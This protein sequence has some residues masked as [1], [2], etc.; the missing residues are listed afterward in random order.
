MN[1]QK[2]CD[3]IALLDKAFPPSHSFVDGLLCNVLAREPGVRLLLLVSRGE[4]GRDNPR[5]YLHTLCWPR[6]FERRGIGRFLNVWSAYFAV[7]KLVR[8]ACGRRTVL[9]V[10]NDPSMLLA[11]ALQRRR[12]DRLVFQSSF[13]HEQGPSIKARVAR[14]MYRLASA[15]V[16]A[17]MGVSPD[18]LARLRTLFP[19]ARAADIVPLLA[20]LPDQTQLKEPAVPDKGGAVRFVYIGLHSAARKLEVVLE[21]I[22]R[23]VQAGANATFTFVGGSPTEHDVLR[24][25]EGVPGLLQRGCLRFVEKVP[26]AEITR[27]LQDADVGLSLIP[28]DPHFKEAS[29]TKVS[30]YMTAGL[31]V[32]ASRGIPLQEQFIEDAQGGVLTDWNPESISAGIRMLCDDRQALGAMRQRSW[33]YARNTLQYASFLPRVKRLIGEP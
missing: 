15:R 31:A 6:L 18:G 28:P 20:G 23:A 11:C 25:T 9:L 21:A 8:R 27:Y 4:D 3:V 33:Q 26:R 7:N 32:L 30:E 22:V 10:R 1:R 13:P 14:W 29:P 24:R 2:A 12:V 17:I 16:D 19:R 5:R